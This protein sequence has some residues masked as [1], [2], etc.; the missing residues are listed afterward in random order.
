[1]LRLKFGELD[2]STERRL[3]AAA[4]EQLDRWSERVLT[5]ESLEVMFAD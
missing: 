2:G 5:A 4:L 3:E 1:L